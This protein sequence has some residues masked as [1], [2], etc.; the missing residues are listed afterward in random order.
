[1][2]AQEIRGGMMRLWDSAGLLS[3]N[4]GKPMGRL[5]FEGRDQLISSFTTAAMVYDSVDGVMT[6]LIAN[7]TDL[8]S[9]IKDPMFRRIPQC[10]MMTDPISSLDRS[11]VDRYCHP[12]KLG[13]SSRWAKETRTP[14]R[15]RKVPKGYIRSTEPKSQNGDSSSSGQKFGSADGELGD[16]QGRPRFCSR[17]RPVIAKKQRSGVAIFS[18][19]SRS[20]KQGDS[21]SR[22]FL[23]I[24]SCLTSS[25]ALFILAGHLRFFYF[26]R[27]GCPFQFPVPK[28]SSIAIADSLANCRLPSSG[29]VLRRKPSPKAGLELSVI[30]HLRFSCELAQLPPRSLPRA[31]K[32]CCSSIKLWEIKGETELLRTATLKAQS[33]GCIHLSLGNSKILFMKIK[34]YLCS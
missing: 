25:S 2:I 8:I 30:C 5:G 19:D 6:S 21:E 22:I 18:H 13:S 33:C 7:P 14:V 10:V 17:R 32:V 29:R 23:A 9:S 4:W 31:Y 12:E 15:L 20:Q 26:L 11:H 16:G 34:I 28:P 27:A 3:E 1:M 24:R